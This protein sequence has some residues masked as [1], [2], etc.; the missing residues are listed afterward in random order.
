MKN[1]IRNPVFPENW[2]MWQ[3]FKF[4]LIFVSTALNMTA[5]EPVYIVSNLEFYKYS[6]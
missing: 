4:Q 5:Q 2:E 1:A 3:V 6:S